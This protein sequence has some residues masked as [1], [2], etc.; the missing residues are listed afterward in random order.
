[1]ILDAPTWAATHSSSFFFDAFEK[2]RWL[3]MCAQASV[4]VPTCLSQALD[5]AVSALPI[6]NPSDARLVPAASVVVRACLPSA[7]RLLCNR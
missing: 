2:S 4:S 5:A 1:M 6:S 3:E 7:F